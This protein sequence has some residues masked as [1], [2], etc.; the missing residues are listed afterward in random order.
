MNGRGRFPPWTRVVFGAALTVLWP[1]A[2]AVGQG[3]S[4]YDYE[5]LS[6][7]G[8][9]VDAGYIWPG[10]VEA[11]EAFGLRADLGYLGPGIRIL[12]R[13]GYWSSRMKA[14]EVRAFEDRV[15]ALVAEQNPGSPRPDVDL[16]VVG[17]SGFSVGT[18][19]QFV[20][21]VPSDVLTFVGLGVA[22][23]FQ[24]GSGEAVE[25][26]FVEDLIDSTVVGANLHAG[27]E[28]PL[29]RRLRAYGDARYEFAGDVRFF[30]VRAGLQ[31][32]FQDPAPGERG[33][34]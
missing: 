29:G 16:G 7:R 22:A 10:I 32:M 9:G 19:A 14:D 20:W 25:D 18:E 28:V 5:D 1:A 34:S 33:T 6:F 8:I 11:T 3:L 21:R 2:P 15:A 31:I 13:V 27:L 12:P 17:W 30:G 26:T 24:N 4:D 23:H